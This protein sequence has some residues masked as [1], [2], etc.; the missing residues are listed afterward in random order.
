MDTPKSC[1]ECDIIAT[2]DYADWCPYKKAKTNIYDYIQNNTRPNWCPLKL[3]PDRMDLNQY[4]NNTSC[5]L[6]NI[7]AYQYAQGWNSFRDEILKGKM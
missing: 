5:G 6:D 4:V 1:A 7:V 3:V 2:D